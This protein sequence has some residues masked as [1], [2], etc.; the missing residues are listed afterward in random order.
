M[1]F[2]LFSNDAKISQAF[3]TKSDV[4]QHAARSGLVTEL[5]SGEED[6]P[7]RILNLGYA[8]HACAPDQPEVSVPRVSPLVK[9]NT[10]NPPTV[11]AAS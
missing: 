1:P 4:W 9:A 5:S 10:V 2:A 6:P 8:I 11:A 3:P 7:R